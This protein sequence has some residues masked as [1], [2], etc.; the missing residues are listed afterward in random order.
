MDSLVGEVIC[1]ADCFGGNES[2][3]MR[4]CCDKVRRNTSEGVRQRMGVTVFAGKMSL[5][6]SI[7][8]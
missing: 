8:N 1:I 7:I 4:V 6:C 3:Q 2:A 5:I